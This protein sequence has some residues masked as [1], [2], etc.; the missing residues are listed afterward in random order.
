MKIIDMVIRM[1]TEPELLLDQEQLE[2]YHLRIRAE[3]ATLLIA[4]GVQLDEVMS[5]DKFA[6]ALLRAGV[7]PPTKISMTTGKQTYA[8]AKTDKGLLALQEHPSDQVQALV[9]ARLGNKS[10]LNET[11]ALK[12]AD[13]AKRGPATVYLKFSGAQQT[14][15]LSGA[16]G[17]NWQNNTRGGVIRNCIHAPDGYL[18]LVADSR[19]IESRVV[20]TLAQQEDA[21]EAYRAFDAGH[22]P[23]IYCVMASK[24]YRRMITPKDKPERQFG[25]VVKL[26]CGFQMGAERFKETARIM[27]GMDLDMGTCA[28]AVNIYRQSHAMV[29]VLWNRGQSA[30]SALKGGPDGDKYLDPK[31]LLIIEQGAILLPNGLRIRYPDLS[32]GG[33]REWTFRS[34][35]GERTKIYGGKIVENVVQALARNIVLEQTL[36]ISREAGVPC[37]LSVH[38]EGV[39]LVPEDRAFEVAAIAGEVMSESPKWWPELPVAVEVQ[40]ARVYGEAK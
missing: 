17:I 3:K 11:R 5:N 20:D 21:V 9:S 10:T 23:D 6:A 33:D 24:I 7:T 30:I 15:R 28:T 31:G 32:F 34:G 35:R 39:F 26:A 25:K 36:K 14:H 16:D 40:I 19:N 37:K 18:L 4:A 2:D 1:F 12:L 8:F 13:M 27:A 22:G 38:D 29:G